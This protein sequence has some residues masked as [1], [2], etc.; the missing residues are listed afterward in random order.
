MTHKTEQQLYDRM[1]DIILKL[2]EAIAL[3]KVPPVI[4]A[5]FPSCDLQRRCFQRAVL[6]TCTVEQ[7]VVSYPNTGAPAE[8]L[9]SWQDISRQKSYLLLRCKIEARDMHSCP[10]FHTPR[11]KVRPRV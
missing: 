4:S 7:I 8:I 3:H 2:N 10:R 6:A 1:V 5:K 9:R 11:S